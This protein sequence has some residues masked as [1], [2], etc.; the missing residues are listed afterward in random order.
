MS[1]WERLEPGDPSQ[2]G[3]YHVL[4]R[5]GTGGMGRVFLARSAAGRWVAVKTI[6]PEYAAVGE[7]RRRFAHEAQ[8]AARVSGVFTASVVDSDPGAHFPWI[9][10][11][12]IPAP[13]LKRL[14]NTCGAQPL[15]TVMWLGAGIA[16]ALQSIHAVG[17]IHRDLKPSN[18]LLA[19]DGPRVIDFGLVHAEGTFVST[20][21][22]AA[23]GTPGYMSPE[24]AYGNVPVTTA[25]DVYSLGLTL[26]QLTNGEDAVPAHSAAG[27][28]DPLRGIVDLCLRR[29]PRERPATAEVIRLLAEQVDLVAHDNA[30]GW[31]D[32]KAWDL[33]RAYRDATLPTM[34]AR[35]HAV[36][37]PPGV[38]P[39][40]D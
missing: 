38:L 31:L 29:D 5:L 40:T 11:A 21:G 15:R 10:T 36:P 34:D 24:Q 4:A 19:E 27:L 30:R 23:I 8:A 1:A 18:I 14:I 2:V 17:V 7:F 22:T 37:P 26:I 33:I 6:H 13:S 39:V 28:P 9:A 20:G 32:E 16:E 35:W 3:P 25:S 12:Y